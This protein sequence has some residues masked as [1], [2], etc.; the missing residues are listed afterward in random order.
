MIRYTPTDADRAPMP[1]GYAAE[2]RYLGYRRDE[3]AK[4]YATVRSAPARSAATFP[5][6]AATWGYDF[7]KTYTA[8]RRHP[9][10]DP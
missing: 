2:P 6:P 9:S 5:P 3:E 10:R 8:R 7:R 1:A 4:P